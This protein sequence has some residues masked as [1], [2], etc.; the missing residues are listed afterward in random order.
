MVQLR[1][2]VEKCNGRRRLTS[3]KNSEVY[4]CKEA[5]GEIRGRIYLAA[6]VERWLGSGAGWVGA[7]IEEVTR[8]VS[9]GKKRYTLAINIDLDRWAI[10]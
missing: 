4:E 1:F 3:T 5:C 2:E 10:V 7:E 8:L 6:D 9:K